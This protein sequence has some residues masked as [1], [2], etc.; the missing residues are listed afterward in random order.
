[1]KKLSVRILLVALASV[2]AASGA[3]CSGGTDTA[4]TTT[5]S[6]Q[7]SV[8]TEPAEETVY[9]PLPQSRLNGFAFRFLNYDETYLSWAVNPLDA[10]EQTGDVL[11]DA[12]WTRNNR[13]EETYDCAISE[14]LLSKPHD[15]IASLVQSGDV[16]AEIVMLYD[17]TVMNKYL[18]GYLQTWDVLPHVDFTEPC[19]S[20][21][22]TQTFSVAG[23]VFAAT[24]AFSLAQSTR[25]FILIF[26]KDMYKDLG[27][28]ED[29]YQLAREG[30]WTMD[31]LVKAEQAAAADLNGDG[32]M[33]TTND[34][35]GNG[36]A[37]KLYFGSLV[38]GAGIKY[39]D[40]DENG[41]PVF[42]IRGNEYAM[43]VMSDILARHSGNYAYTT[44]ASGIH[45]GSNEARELFKSNKLLFLGSSMKAVNQYRD[46]ENDIG[47]LPFPKYSE[48]QDRYY[49][50]TSG[51]SMAA[52]PKTL[53]QTAFEPV[54]LI[55]EALTR[56]SEESVVPVYKEILL[57]SKYARD[58]GSADMLDIIFASA[59]Y[60]IGLSVMPGE[61]YYKYMEVFL[62]GTDTFSSLTA[63][64]ADSVSAKLEE[65]TLVG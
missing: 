5:Q 16:G 34:R 60:D 19:W 20:L 12:I 51:G 41:T 35:F 44:V 31:S 29:L 11:N 9:S 46:M 18:S 27:L 43:T 65:L 56:D 39:I 2:L 15:S 63:S 49:A 13:V 53:A 33:D 7:S 50:L 1:M 37:I 6:V 17:E 21:D 3:G 58:Q 40:L 30:K 45:N 36:G 64:I 8:Q 54:G 10:E 26:N 47:L 22:A 23:K 25:S 62:S 57:K 24:G 14:V 28:K 55:L 38:T 48:E 61:T 42:A 32:A 4:E 59:V 52:I